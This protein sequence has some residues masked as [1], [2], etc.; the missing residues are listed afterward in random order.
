MAQKKFDMEELVESALNDDSPDIEEIDSDEFEEENAKTKSKSKNIDDDGEVLGAFA[1]DILW[2]EE[3][4]WKGFKYFHLEGMTERTLCIKFSKFFGK[5]AEE[6]ENFITSCMAKKAYHKLMH[7]FCHTANAILNQDK[8][9]TQSFLYRYYCLKRDLDNDIF[10]QMDEAKNIGS[11]I[12]NVVSLFDVNIVNEIRKYV[13]SQYIPINSPKF[14]ENRHIFIESITFTE[15]HIKIMY[16][17]SRMVHLIA[18]LCLEYLKSHPRADAKTFLGETFTALFPL[19]ENCGP[20]IV[21][22]SEQDHKCDVYQK[23]CSFVQSKVEGTLKSDKPMWERQAQFGVNWRNTTESIV[24]KLIVDIVPEYS[25]RGNIMNMNSAV[26]RKSIIDY[27]LRKKDLYSIS[28]FAD[29]DANSSDDDNSVI[30][31]SEQFDSFNSKHDAFSIYIRHTFTEDTV[32]KIIERM[33]IIINPSDVEYYMKN[34][35][36]HKF[37]T[38]AI[39]A[40]VLRPFG[41]TENI[42]SLNQEN[43]IKLMLIISS[44]MKNLGMINLSNF[45]TGIKNRHYISKKESRVSHAILMQDPIYNYIVDMKYSGIKNIITKKNNFIESRISY[46]MNNEFSY[47]LPDSD[48]TGQIIPRSEDVIREETLKFFNEFIL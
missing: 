48:L 10:D 16:I 1:K 42:Y 20:G 17:L 14:E 6:Y 3:P 19:A 44:S 27:T 31:E 37:Q 4:T 32:N 29:V 45:V 21:S 5:D 36:F 40:S 22:I 9:A 47:N 18:P 38:F 8:K 43:Y 28:Q 13:N 46:L 39:F 2:T 7:L 33:G 15:Y 25:F 12:S 35:H 30:S 11:F 34:I 41:G 23:L 24:S 26:T